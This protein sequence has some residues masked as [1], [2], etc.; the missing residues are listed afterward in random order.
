METTAAIAGR[1]SIRRFKEQDVPAEVLAEV[2]DAATQAP[3]AM[4]RQNW[5]FVVLSGRRKDT[6][7][8]AMR[9]QAPLA[10]RLGMRAEGFATSVRSMESA[11]VVVLVFNSGAQPE[12]GNRSFVDERIRAFDLFS[13][14]AATENLL[15]RA[16]DLGLGSVCIGWVAV[17]AEQI[18]RMLGR[19][20]ELV[21]AVAL[22]YPAESPAPRSRRGFEEVIEQA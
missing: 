10:A 17:A 16:T 22:G 1:R 3:S 18:A 19:S 20:E 6:L 7:V 14:G 13:I 9:A 4:N 8:D 12:A 11:P 15:L 2:L 5:R 21:V